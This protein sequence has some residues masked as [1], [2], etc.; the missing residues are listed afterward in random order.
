M[1]LEGR[2]KRKEKKKWR[3][4][5]ESKDFRV[6]LRVQLSIHVM[7]P[8]CDFYSYML[9]QVQAEEHGVGCTPH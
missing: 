5:L 4:Q 2:M 3:K 7:P 8:L 1:V 9:E 6:L